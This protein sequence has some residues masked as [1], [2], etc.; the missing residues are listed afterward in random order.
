MSPSASVVLTPLGVRVCMFGELREMNV[1]CLPSIAIRCERDSF[2]F[3]S[4]GR[5]A[6]HV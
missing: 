6:M 5:L 3:S 4:V 2:L 1:V